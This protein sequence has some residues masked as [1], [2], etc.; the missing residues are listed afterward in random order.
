MESVP[1]ATAQ[2]LT[3]LVPVDFS[4]G[5]A[6][7]FR[8]AARLAVPLGA[9]LVV[10][11]IRPRRHALKGGRE[12]VGQSLRQEAA[13]DEIHEMA[14]AAAPDLP[15]AFIEVRLREDCAH[16]GIV[17][18]AKEIGADFI[19]VARHGRSS[20]STGTLGHTVEYVVA[21]APCSVLLADGR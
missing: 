1:L 11:H 2:R 10:V 4:P 20:N 3:F 9:R 18:E 7:A 21:H 12:E 13:I 15:D 5:S 17:R 14:S 16:L 8:L 6:A 19:V